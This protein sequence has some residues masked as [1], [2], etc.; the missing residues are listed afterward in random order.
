VICPQVKQTRND[1]LFCNSALA[2][3]KQDDLIP[4]LRSSLPVNRLPN[5]P[6][7]LSQTILKFDRVYNEEYQY[8]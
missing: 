1:M 5:V 7:K 8:L 2:R 3:T 6:D 4:E